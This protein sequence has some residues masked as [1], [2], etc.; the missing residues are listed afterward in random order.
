MGGGYCIVCGGSNNW[1][2]AI[3]LFA[4]VRI[5]GRR[6]LYCLRRFE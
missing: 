5:S 2:E 3:V 4:E 1:E 6:P